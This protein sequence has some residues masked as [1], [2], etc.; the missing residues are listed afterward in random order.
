MWTSR[1]LQQLVVETPSCTTELRD[2]RLFMHCMH[3]SHQI[4]LGF[5]ECGHFIVM[6]VV[7]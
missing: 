7:L 6:L 3:A 5:V 4:D 2:D 1:G